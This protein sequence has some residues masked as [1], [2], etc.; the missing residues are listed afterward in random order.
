VLNGR[1]TEI[2]VATAEQSSAADSFLRILEL[3]HDERQGIQLEQFF[4]YLRACMGHTVFR[5]EGK[6]EQCGFLTVSLIT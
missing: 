4:D 1:T 3:R 6:R 5:K 2:K